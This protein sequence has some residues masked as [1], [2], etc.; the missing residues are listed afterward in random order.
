[1]DVSTI[2]KTREL[3][4]SCKLKN[5]KSLEKFIMFPQ[6]TKSPFSARD[7]RDEERMNME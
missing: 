7:E 5:S 3:L 1:M 6:E 4:T 2:S